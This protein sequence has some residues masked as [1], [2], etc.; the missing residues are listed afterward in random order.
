M[1][2]TRVYHSV[3][4]FSVEACR[5][6]EKS[7]KNG[8]KNYKPRGRVSRPGS[9][10]VLCECAA[11][12]SALHS[13][14][15]RRAVVA[16]LGMPRALPPSLRVG[17]PLRVGPVPCT[18]AAR[19]AGP[20]SLLA[21]G[22]PGPALPSR[23]VLRCSASV[24]GDPPRRAAPSPALAGREP[25]ADMFHIL[26]LICAR[27][28]TN[29]CTHIGRYARIDAPHSDTTIGVRS[30]LPCSLLSMPGPAG[31]PGAT[32]VRPAASSKLSARLRGQTEGSVPVSS[33]ESAHHKPGLHE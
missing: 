17:P 3:L 7:V 14:P 9:A 25:T 23:R 31:R 26:T 30:V 5:S 10:L 1:E 18:D 8:R 12:V 28:N 15:A 32:P 24:R 33:S 27:F 21:V 22:E 20:A 29:R 6:V 16:A 19:A 11:L 4:V 13:A 2:G